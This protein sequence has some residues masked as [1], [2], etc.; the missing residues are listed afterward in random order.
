MRM[1]PR[2]RYSLLALLWLAA[3]LYSL[4]F[5]EAAGGAPPF[6]HFDKVAHFALF[7]GQ[8][9]LAAKAFMQAQRPI[10]YAALFTLAVLLAAGSE[11]A[12]ALFTQSRQ[13]DL[14][15]GLA[16][17][18]GAATALWLAHKVSTAKKQAV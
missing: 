5:R 2:N 12:Q 15:D 8:F 13:G 6:A 4:L 10:P 3:G 18:A 7:F 11:V 1:M 17:V 9:W 16:D 14:L